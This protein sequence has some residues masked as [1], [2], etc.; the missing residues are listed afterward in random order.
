MQG[1]G[2]FEDLDEEFDF[3]ETEIENN[4][5]KFMIPRSVSQKHPPYL[6]FKSVEQMDENIEQ[7]RAEY[8]SRPPNDEWKSYC[9]SILTSMQ[10]MYDD[11]FFQHS[12]LVVI[13]LTTGSSAIKC[14]LKKV[15]IKNNELYIGVHEM[16]PIGAMTCDEA[17]YSFV[18]PIKKSSFDG[19]TVKIDIRKVYYRPS[20]D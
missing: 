14:K 4:T 8:D 9:E 13:L 15:G 20:D 18:I 11:A 16:V 17:Y 12:N 2:A 5:R 1:P 7:I 3:D 19:D 6:M 10:S